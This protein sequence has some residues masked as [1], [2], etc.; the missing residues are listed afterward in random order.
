MRIL[1]ATAAIAL[2]SLTAATGAMGQARPAS[3]EQE[4]RGSH[5]G[6]ALFLRECGI[7]HL[8]GGTGTMM[9]SRRLGEGKS[10]I[11]ERGDLAP[12]YVEMVVRRGVNSMP[13]ITRVEL[14][15]AE[16][17]AIIGYLTGKRAQQGTRA[18]GRTS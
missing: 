1:L 2:L 10:F 6:E 5:S 11:A 13:T 17:Q 8:P 7:C 12:Q 3:A 9:L 14:P 16:L 18:S 15:D 4:D